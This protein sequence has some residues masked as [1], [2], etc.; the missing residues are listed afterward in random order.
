L[1]DMKQPRTTFRAPAPPGARSRQGL[2][3]L[4]LLFCITLLAIGI[5]AIARLTVGMA[6]AG[7]M[8][9]DAELASQ[10]ARAML[11]RIQAE[12]FSQAFRSFN[13][14]PADDPGGPGTAPGANFAVAGLRAL[15]GDPDGL[16][17]E[18][19]FPTGAGQPGVLSENVVDPRL[20]MPRDLDGNGLVDGANHAT[21]YNL[22]PVLVRVRWQARDGSAGAFELQTVLANY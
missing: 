13:A 19:V 9:H 20:G 4:E 12:S 8:A 17:G 11:E 22:L 15:P 21:N 3:L 18:V 2:T 7:G 10:A 14:L 1:I 16:P 5:S 6:R